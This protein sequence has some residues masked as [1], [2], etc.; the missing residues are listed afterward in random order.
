MSSPAR[1]VRVRIP[2]AVS[3][4]GEYHAEAWSHYDD[5]DKAGR[6]A[7]AIKILLADPLSHIVWIEA[8]VPVPGEPVAVV[9]EVL[10]VK[11]SPRA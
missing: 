5:N 1:T 10:D 7:S 11:E 9:A 3:R 6:L 8:D 2:V 4:K